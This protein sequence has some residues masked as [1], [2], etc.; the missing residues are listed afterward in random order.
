[1]LE[2][3]KV[4]AAG[5]LFLPCGGRAAP[6]PTVRVPTGVPHTHFPGRLLA[7]PTCG[8]TE[9]RP[10]APPPGQLQPPGL[11]VALQNFA[12]MLFVFLLLGCYMGSLS[13]V[14]FALKWK[15]K[16]LPQ[17]GSWPNLIFYYE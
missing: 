7:C 3:P 15:I 4:R 1:M 2:A 10:R 8:S 12:V 11:S 5:A 14:T 9:A 17:T 13:S 16:I 6:W